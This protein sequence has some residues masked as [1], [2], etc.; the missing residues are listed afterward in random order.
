M[1]PQPGAITSLH[2][3]SALASTI[4]TWDPLGWDPLIDH[5]RIYA[6]PDETAPGET[7]PGEDALGE[8]ASSEATR[9]TPDESDLLA[10]TV[11]PRFVHGDLDPAGETWSYRVLAVSDAGVRGE[12]SEAVTGSSQASVTVTGRAVATIGDF[13]GRSLEHRYAPADYARIP[14][15]YPDAVIEYEQQADTP[16][17]SWPYLLPGP[18]DA[19]AGSREHRARWHLTIEQP[20][21]R[22]D[23][24]LWLVD[25]TRLGG[26]LRISVDGEH[27]ADV[28]LTR[29]AT[30]GSS[31]GDATE[32]GSLLVRSYHELEIPEGMLPEGK[33][34]IELHLIAGG[35]VAW[36]AV[37]VFVRE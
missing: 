37:G 14:E 12:P 15:D 9:W 7:A 31:E 27:L 4:L 2:V 20:Q 6:V 1:S 19:W 28:E 30:K 8:E 13:D 3:E 24:A 25:T 33:C 34:V 18:G 21:A 29:G 26:A 11:Y 5:Y 36:D 10:K 23:L 22:H 17:E 16:E 35:W 32:P